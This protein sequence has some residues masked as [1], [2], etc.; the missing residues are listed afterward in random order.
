MFLVLNDFE[1][2]V[3]KQHTHHLQAFAKVAM[4]FQTDY[5]NLTE[6]F[7][8]AWLRKVLSGFPKVLHRLKPIVFRENV[9]TH[10]ILGILSILQDLTPNILIE[11]Q[12]ELVSKIQRLWDISGLEINGVSSLSVFEA[13]SFH[14]AEFSATMPPTQISIKMVGYTDVFTCLPTSAI[15]L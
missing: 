1:Y 12:C 15:Y 13:Q 7:W 14:F 11:S 9:A 4:N 2:P 10:W 5:S 8:K 3:L 6:I